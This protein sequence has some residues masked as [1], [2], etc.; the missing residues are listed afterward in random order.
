MSR[1][2]PADPDDPKQTRTILTRCY[3]CG[4][5]FEAVALSVRCPACRNKARGTDEEKKIPAN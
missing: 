3:G 1:F 2:Q 5:R 4:Q